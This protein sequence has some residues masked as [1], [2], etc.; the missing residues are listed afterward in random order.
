MGMEG[1]RS[2]SQFPSNSSSRQRQSEKAPE[3]HHAAASS[4]AMAHHSHHSRLDDLI[5]MEPSDTLLF[6]TI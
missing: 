3:E 1:D 4:P 5:A 2:A 6:G